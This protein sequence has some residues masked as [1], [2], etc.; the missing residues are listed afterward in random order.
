MASGERTQSASGRIPHVDEKLGTPFAAARVEDLSAGRPADLRDIWTIFSDLV[1]ARPETRFHFHFSGALTQRSAADLHRKAASLAATLHRLGTR[2]GDAIVAQLPNCEEGVVAFAAAMGLG[3]VYVPVVP[4]YGPAELGF[5]IRDSG[6]KVLICPRQWNRIDFEQRLSALPEADRPG[7]VVMLEASQ[8]AIGGVIDWTEAT[9]ATDAPAR[10][11]G[12]DCETP[13]LVL[14]T[15]GT[16]SRPKGVKHCHRSLVADAWQSDILLRHLK[17]R[18]FLLG[19]P[20]GHV[21][22]ILM[23]IRQ[24]LYG[25][26]GVHLDRWDGSVA[27]DLIDRFQLG[28]SVGVPVHLDNLIPFAG[29][30]RL[31]SLEMYLVGGTSV[32]GK[33]VEDAAAVGITACR[34]YG[35]T[36]HPTIAQCSPFHDIGL[37]SRS[38]GYLMAGCQVRVLDEDGHDLP[39]GEPG[40]LLT[41]GPELFMGYVDGSLDAEAF[42]PGGWFRTG[43]IGTVQADG[44]LLVTGRKK[45][46]IIRAG[47]NISAQEVEETL[48]RHPAVAEAAVVGWPDKAYGERVGA[49]A[50]LRA[51]A[52][53]DLDAVGAH[54]RASGLARQKTPERLMILDAFPRNPAGKILKSELRKLAASQ[55]DAG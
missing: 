32:S 7:H 44:L 25:L 41:K 4:I 42:A 35:S 24:F 15:S 34:T 8:P 9:G 38:D 14:Y 13:C 18:E 55:Q 33:L 46:I 17:R 43:D 3:L 39:P 51:G 10:L 2:P 28:W 45:D 27:A 36:E 22:P 20:A 52:S 1:A 50:V 12:W 47:E 26:D 37:R 6:A 31:R 48:S 23:I 19:A 29:Q 53:L 40:E 54:F 11:G 21:G 5:I 16:T 49:F 30:G